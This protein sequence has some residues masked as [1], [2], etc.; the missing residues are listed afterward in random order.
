MEATLTVDLTT[1]FLIPDRS[2]HLSREAWGHPRRCGCAVSPIDAW[3][4][5]H[6]LGEPCAERAKGR[7]AHVK[8]HFGDAQFSAAQESHSPFDTTGHEI[9]IRAFSIRLVKLTTEMSSGHVNATRKGLDVEGLRILA[10]NPV[11]RQTK[12]S[13]LTTTVHVGIQGCRR[14]VLSGSDIGH[15]RFPSPDLRPWSI[16]EVLTVGSRASSRLGVAAGGVDALIHEQM[17]S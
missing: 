8:A 2:G 7:V 15:G 17:V 11:P 12:S 10:I 3:R 9:R 16:G 1:R 14:T 13:E 4:N 5:A 6:Q